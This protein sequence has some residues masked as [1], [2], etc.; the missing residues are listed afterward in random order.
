M[1][2]RSQYSVYSLKTF[3]PIKSVVSTPN[4]GIGLPGTQEVVLAGGEYEAILEQRYE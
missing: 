2:F 1:L 4:T 3:I